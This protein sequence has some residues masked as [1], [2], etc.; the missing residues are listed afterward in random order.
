MSHKIK[1]K[2]LRESFEKIGVLEKVEIV[3]DPFTGDSRGFGFIT[4][5]TEEDA[6]KAAEILNKTDLQGRNISVELAKRTRAR[7]PTPGRYLG[8]FRSRRRRYGSRSRSRSDS[9]RRGS[10]HRSSRHYDNDRR[11]SSY[12]YSGR[13]GRRD[14]RRDYDRDSRRDRYGSGRHRED[15][16]R[17]PR[18]RS[19]SI[20]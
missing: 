13:E 20:S 14:S 1:E 2:H 18:R 10:R 5:R 16:R 15:T 3:K 8:K 4:Y 6:K 11:E 19:R 12:R 9:Y 17:R 7:G